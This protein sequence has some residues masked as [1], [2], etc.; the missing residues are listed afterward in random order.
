MFRIFIL[1]DTQAIASSLSLRVTC[2]PDNKGLAAAA[3][4]VPNQS[5]TENNPVQAT[6]FRQQIESDI[7]QDPQLK[8]GQ[9]WSPAI[10]PVQSGRF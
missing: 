8:R 4:V 3:N 6:S 1:S 7:S 5:F 2:Y 10:S 9:R